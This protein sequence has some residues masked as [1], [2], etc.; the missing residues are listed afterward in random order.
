VTQARTKADLRRLAVE[1]RTTD[2]GLTE[3]Q[4]LDPYLLA[5]EHGVDIYSL[6]D[7]AGAGCPQETIDFFTSVKP[8]AWSAALVPA[9]TGRFIIENHAHTPPRRRSNLGHEM[10]H[11][12]LEHEFDRILFS[13]GKGCR[14]PANRPLEREAAELAG[15]LLLPIAAARPA[16]I[17]GCPAEELADHFGVSIEIARWRMNVSGGYTIAQRATER[18]R[19]GGP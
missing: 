16:A 19:R 13:D 12:L 11:L 3:R 6:A 15:E 14:D 2:L 10:A 1:I 5:R 9:G 4:P 8:D 18:R 17:K 7:L